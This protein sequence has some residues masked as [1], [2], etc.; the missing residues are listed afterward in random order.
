MYKMEDYMK[1]FNAFTL[2]EVLI[3][4]GIIGVVAAITIPSL[5][6]NHKKSEVT[7][8]LKKIYSVVNQAINLAVSENGDI[9]E[10]I[11]YCGS[12]GAPICTSEQAMQ[13]FNTYI[14][15]HMQIIKSE[16]LDGGFNLYF[17]DGSILYIENCIYDMIFYLNKKALNSRVFGKN[18]FA[19]RFNPVLFSD[20]NV[21]NN[22]HTIKQSFE[23]YAYSWD[24][25]RDNLKNNSIYGCANNGNFCAKLI[26]YDGWQIKDDY[27]V[28]F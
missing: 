3:T 23:P 22:A 15:K 19:F 8:K 26:Q 6:A 28:K 1:R 11:I 16:T 2:A 17:N 27:P 25:T 18:A 24:G 21:N 13:W 10:W 14:G 20:Q 5:V 9:N 12:S 4:L 7:T